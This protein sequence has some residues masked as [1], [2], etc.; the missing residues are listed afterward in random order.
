[1]V[2]LFLATCEKG[3]EEKQKHTKILSIK[4][5]LWTFFFLGRELLKN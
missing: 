1:M 2:L 5:K 3:D 4:K